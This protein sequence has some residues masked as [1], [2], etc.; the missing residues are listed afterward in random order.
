M[1]TR[2]DWARGR[3]TRGWLNPDYEKTV[4]TR[5]YGSSTDMTSRFNLLIPAFMNIKILFA[6][7]LT[8]A[9]IALA[10]LAEEDDYGCSILQQVRDF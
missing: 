3:P 7:L 1:L 4:A 9:S 6:T 2:Q 5:I 10:I 8:S